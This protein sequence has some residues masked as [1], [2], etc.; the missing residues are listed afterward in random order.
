[1][2][3]TRSN[4]KQHGIVIT[5]PCVV[6]N[7]LDAVEYKSSNNLAN[8]RITEPASGDGAFA[9][10]ILKRLLKSSQEFGFSFEKSLSNLEFYEIDSEKLKEL[11][12]SI[13]K[14]FKSVK[15]RA[16][17]QFVF[18]EDFLLA[19]SAKCDILI[20]NPPYV[21]HEN[22]P[23][24]LKKQYKKNF[25]TFK[26]RSD[27]YIPFFEKG[28]KLLKNDGVLCFICSNRWLK[29]QYGETL[30][31]LISVK[32][33]VDFIIDLEKADAFQ[34]SVIAYPSIIK[35]DNTQVQS[36][37]DYFELDN[38]KDLAKII[39]GKSEAH[40][41]LAIRSSNW[42]I[43][44][45][46]NGKSDSHLE[47]IETQGFKIGIGVATGCDRVY[48]NTDFQ[49]Q[50][51]DELLMPLLMSRDL[52]NDNF[53][54]R[55]NYIINPFTRN[56]DLIDLDKYPKAKKYF[57][58]N[59]EVLR[60]RH[61]AKKNPSNWIKTIDKIKPEL[62]IQNK[63]ILPDIS[64]N[65]NIFIDEGNYYPHHNLYY[66]TGR[67]L[68]DLKVLAAILLSD[69]VRFQLS[70]IGNKMNG[71]YPRWQSQYLKK[72]RIP[73]INSL[74]KAILKELI[75]AFENFDLE[76]INSLIQAKNIVEYNVPNGQLIMFEPKVE[77]ERISI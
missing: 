33:K 61:V 28:L 5:K 53:R 15:V 36:G 9:L 6:N 48:I 38:V 51:E 35:I 27:L 22:I 16:D 7:M 4:G 55:G 41:K 66:I 56:G 26:H 2:Y 65:K 72:L 47:L 34:E 62:K 13:Q 52:K 18:E 71:G 76:K 64:G 46:L 1:M 50:I 31:Y 23:S 67:N 8:V 39:S 11:N 70:T 37:T 19:K 75:E 14:F 44:E 69:F 63:I 10:E 21:R 3:G 74:P 32:Y 59:E 25:G 12:L 68:S 30:R 73:R 24:E 17:T 43:N 45:P 40:K 58:E 54:W 20:G 60:K 57:K 42:F 29:N 49:N 77:Y